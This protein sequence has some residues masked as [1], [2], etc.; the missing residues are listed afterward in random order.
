M[1]FFINTS[2]ELQLCSFHKTEV[3]DTGIKTDN[4]YHLSPAVSQPCLPT[5]IDS[6]SFINNTPPLVVLDWN[7]DNI[8]WLLQKY[9]II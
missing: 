7:N 9:K 6:I 3:R 5:C 4:I 2:T 8:K 1:F